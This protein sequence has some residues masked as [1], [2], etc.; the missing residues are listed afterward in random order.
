[1]QYNRKGTCSHGS[2]SHSLYDLGYV[3]SC[4]WALF[5]LLIKIKGLA[6]V[7][8]S[9]SNVT[10]FYV[11]QPAQ[12]LYSLFPNGEED[13]T[14]LTPVTYRRNYTKAIKYQVLLVHTSFF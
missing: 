7:V 5:S 6:V 9:S 13:F 4:L 8:P 10:G 1:M 11:S 12:I 2:D 14:L 3:I